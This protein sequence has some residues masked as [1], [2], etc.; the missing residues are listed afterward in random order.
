M[1]VAIGSGEDREASVRVEGERFVVGSGHEC[2]LVLEDPKAAPLHAYFEVG[3][4]GRVVLHDLGSGT[5]VDGELIEGS[6]VIEGGEEVRIGDT[7]LTPTLEDPSTEAEAVA[8]VDTVGE[9]TEMRKRIRVATAL[10][11]G[12]VLLA[13]AGLVAFL[14]TRGGG[15]PSPEQVVADAKKRTVLVKAEIPGGESGGT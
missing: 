1:W 2:Q 8:A 6:H 15:K 14:A 9:H 7:I 12:A 5:F 11:A 10:G 4:G 3:E 13:L